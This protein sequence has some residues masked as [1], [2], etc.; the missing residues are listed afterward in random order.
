MREAR[1]LAIPLLMLQRR[2][3]NLFSLLPNELIVSILD[4]AT[5][6]GATETLRDHDARRAAARRAQIAADA[7][8]ARRIQEELSVEDAVVASFLNG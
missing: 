5:E 6:G 7:E 1:R 4:H 2:G 3:D 8:M